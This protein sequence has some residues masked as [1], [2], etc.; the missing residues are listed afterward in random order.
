MTDAGEG[1]ALAIQGG[2]FD[3]NLDD[4]QLAVNNRRNFLSSQAALALTVGARVRIIPGPK[5]HPTDGVTAT[6]TDIKRTTVH[7]DLDRAVRT[8]NG[9]TGTAWR[10]PASSLEVI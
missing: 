6:V 1:I 9:Y 8:R 10:F 7:I 5:P 2:A 3:D 4:I